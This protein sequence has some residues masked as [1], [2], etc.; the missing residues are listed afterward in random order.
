[1]DKENGVDKLILDVDTNAISR[2][3]NALI[4]GIFRLK[5]TEFKCLIAL[6]SQIHD[7]N[8]QITYV[9][10]AKDLSSLMNLSKTNQYV[11]LARACRNLCGKHI[12]IEWT[13]VKGK[14]SWLDAAWFDHIQCSDGIVEF[15]FGSKVL[16]LLTTV[17]IGYVT[18]EINLLMKFSTTYSLRLYLF[19]REWSDTNSKPKQI[20][21]EYLKIRFGIVEK[22]KKITDLMKY[23]LNPGKKEIEKLFAPI[24]PYAFR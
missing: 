1:M 24:Q 12:Y 13:S 10:K 2:I 6:A 5:V 18:T 23:V 17:A 19:L 22:Y 8:S 3:A 21:I 16:P 4:N 20:S 9:V 11:Q 15:R 14:K 7:D